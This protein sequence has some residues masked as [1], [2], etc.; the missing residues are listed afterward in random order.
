MT[1][2]NPTTHEMINNNFDKNTKTNNNGH[3]TLFFT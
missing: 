2:F 3:L 1:V